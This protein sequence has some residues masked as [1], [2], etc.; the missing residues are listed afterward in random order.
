MTFVLL[1]AICLLYGVSA[2]SENLNEILNQISSDLDKKKESGATNSTST[3]TTKMPTQDATQ[4]P[5]L[6]KKRNIPSASSET[7]ASQSSHSSGPRYTGSGRVYKVPELK[8]LVGQKLHNAWLYGDFLLRNVK[9][10]IGFFI[11]T[12]II[13]LPAEGSTQVQIEFPKGITL[14]QE[15]LNT[16][17]DSMVVLPVSFSAKDPMLLLGVTRMNN[18]QLLVTGRARG[19]LRL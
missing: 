16:L 13:L 1:A 17:H 2:H 12:A 8:D 19:S 11:T 4:K 18:G 3:Q 14:S 9:G 7:L 10:N 5:P 6:G 15:A